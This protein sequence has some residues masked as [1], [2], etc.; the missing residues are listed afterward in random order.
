MKIDCFVTN[1]NILML[2]VSGVA[3]L[4]ALLYS[5]FLLCG[6]YKEDDNVGKISPFSVQC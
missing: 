3:M 1:N 2:D 4:R 6:Q 5:F